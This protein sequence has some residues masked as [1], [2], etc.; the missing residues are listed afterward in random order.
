MQ[1]EDLFLLIFTDITIAMDRQ[2]RLYL[3]D[4]LGISGQM[5]SGIA[6]EL[7]NPLASIV[8]VVGIVNGR[9]S[10]GQ[11]Q[12]RCQIINSEGLRAAGVVKNMLSFAS[13]HTPTNSRCK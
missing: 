9:G 2:D 1:E 11:C 8:G 4:R 13:I 10:A 3:T 5:A 6:H 12:R 7:N